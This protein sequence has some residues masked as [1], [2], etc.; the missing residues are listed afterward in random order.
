MIDYLITVTAKSTWKKFLEN[1][2]LLQGISDGRIVGDSRTL[3][4]NLSNTYTG[5]CTSFA[6]NCVRDLE[7]L[8]P[9]GPAGE[10]YWDFKFYDLKGHR[11]ARCEKTGV[12]IDSSS[13]RG[14]FVL[15]EGP[16]TSLDAED[17]QQWRFLKGE[18][19]FLVERGNRRKTSA[20]FGPISPDLCMTTCLREIAQD[21]RYNNIL[22]LFRHF[23]ETTGIASYYGMVKWDLRLDMRQLELIYNLSDRNNKAIIKWDGK[24]DE[25]SDKACRDK[26]L[27][28]IATYGGP[29]EDSGTRQWYNGC[30]NIL[31]I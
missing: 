2:K 25:N 24:G 21:K 14:A 18:S 20:D 22:C 23:D 29:K 16:W 15:D 27:W 17:D 13:K 11:V 10:G 28:F 12:L 6:L 1:P 19:K 8:K 9:V 3:F 31:D 30:W 26:L 5:R 7:R 4:D